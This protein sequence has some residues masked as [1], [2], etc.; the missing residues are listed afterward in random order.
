MRGNFRSIRASE[1]NHER[2]SLSFRISLHSRHI[3]SLDDWGPLQISEMH[4][5]VRFGAFFLFLAVNSHDKCRQPDQGC[6]HNSQS[7]HFHTHRLRRNGSTTCAKDTLVVAARQYGSLLL[8]RT[9]IVP[10]EES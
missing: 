4:D 8:L 9:Q 7:I 2:L 1:A 10:V 5:L 3:A 6:A